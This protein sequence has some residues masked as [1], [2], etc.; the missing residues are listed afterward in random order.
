MSTM[1][2]ALFQQAIISKLVADIAGHPL[3]RAAA[4]RH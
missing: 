2:Y 1:N 3:T 4:S